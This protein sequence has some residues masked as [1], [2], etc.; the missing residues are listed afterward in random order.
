M[1]HV[2]SCFYFAF[3]L[4]WQFARA[5]NSIPYTGG[6]SVGNVKWRIFGRKALYNGGIKLKVRETIVSSHTEYCHLSMIIKKDSFRH[7]RCGQDIHG[8]ARLAILQSCFF[9][10]LGHKT[11]LHFTESLSVNY[12]QVTEFQRMGCKQMLIVLVSNP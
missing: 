12:N 1:L 3:L 10:L 11:K 6:Y 9:S 7:T 8:V 4:Y 5:Q 2:R